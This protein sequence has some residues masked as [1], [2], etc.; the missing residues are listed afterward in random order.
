MVPVRLAHIL[1][2]IAI[3]SAATLWLL[4]RWIDTRPDKRVR[5]DLTKGPVSD[6]PQDR[7]ARDNARIDEAVEDTF[8]A[9]DPPAFSQSVV[10]GTPSREEAT[11][12]KDRQPRTR[13]DEDAFAE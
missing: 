12:I 9:S 4:Q 11:T 6:L 13:A 8:P 1:A 5:E 10:V 7:E 3:G 2:G